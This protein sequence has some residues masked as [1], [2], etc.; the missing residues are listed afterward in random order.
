MRMRIVSIV[1]A[2]IPFLVAAG[3]LLALMSS[4]G[5]E[6]WGVMV[7]FLYASIALTALGFAAIIL[8]F[9]KRQ[10]SALDIPARVISI[11]SVFVFAPPAGFGLI[12]GLMMMFPPAVNA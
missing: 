9:L 1:L 6:G 7:A 4:T 8:A 12:L 2:A 11:A 3:F 10:P 5:P